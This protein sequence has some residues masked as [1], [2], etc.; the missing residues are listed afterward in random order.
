MN[1]KTIR[2]GVITVH[3]AILGYLCLLFLFKKPIEPRRAIKI[4]THQIQPIA[5]QTNPTKIGGKATTPKAKASPKKSAQPPSPSIASELQ[6]IGKELE[7]LTSEISI[8]HTTC[9]IDI[10]KQIDIQTNGPISLSYTEALASFLERHFIL[11]ERGEVMANLTI[12]PDGLV[13]S[14]E[15]IKTENQKNSDFL[16]KHLH[17]SSFPCFNEFG[18]VAKQLNIT[19]TFKNDEIR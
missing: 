19:I 8:S 6:K 1:L 10:P 12:Q 11:P 16:K 9:S 7:A 14:V 18:F 13:T 5:I 2:T 17:Q 15:I 3:L 4:R